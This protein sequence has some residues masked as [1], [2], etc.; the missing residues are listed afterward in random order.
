MIND[1]DA[2][3][4]VGEELKLVMAFD[5]LWPYIWHELDLTVSWEQTVNLWSRRS[6]Q[7]TIP[8][9]LFE[10]VSKVLLAVGVEVL[11]LPQSI[12]LLRFVILDYFWKFLFR[13]RDLLFVES[14][15]WKLSDWTKATLHTIF[16]ICQVDPWLFLFLSLVSKAFGRFAGTCDASGR[17]AVQKTKVLLIDWLGSFSSSPEH[18]PHLTDR[19][20]SRDDW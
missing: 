16:C 9:L 13:L 18:R 17:H 2:K 20:G 1:G 15:P 6:A 3:V 11:E 7:R 19:L 12:L 5:Q 8:L 4:D 14:H 10:H